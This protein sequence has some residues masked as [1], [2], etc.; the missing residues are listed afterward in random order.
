ME[1]DIHHVKDDEYLVT[2]EPDSGFSTEHRVT[3]YTPFYQMLTQGKITKEE[4]LQ[5]S[6]EFLLEREA[7]SAI[8]PEFDVPDISRYFPEYERCMRARINK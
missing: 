7:N 5:Y 2:V 3:L 1:I 4:L 6:F 8:L